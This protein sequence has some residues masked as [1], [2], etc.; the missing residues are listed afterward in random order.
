MPITARR[1]ATHEDDATD[2][3]VSEEDASRVFFAY[4]QHWLQHDELSE[5][6]A[7]RIMHAAQRILAAGRGDQRG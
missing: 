5:R 2:D 4:L 6:M 1:R 7:Q 3:V